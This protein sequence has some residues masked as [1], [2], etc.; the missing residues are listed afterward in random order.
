MAVYNYIDNGGWDVIQWCFDRMKRDEK[1]LDTLFND[2]QKGDKRNMKESNITA[3][4]NRLWE[5][6]NESA[7]YS[8]ET[9]GSESD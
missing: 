5:V 7:E 4:M 3:R 6:F 8:S 9:S 1:Y 2:L